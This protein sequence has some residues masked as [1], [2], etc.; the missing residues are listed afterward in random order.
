MSRLG[1]GPV[2]LGL[3]VLGLLVVAVATRP[4]VLA[5][6]GLGT[7]AGPVRTIGRQEVVA[8][9][10]QLGPASALGL[11]VMAA[12]GAMLLAR[13]LVAVVLGAV[14]LLAAGAAGWTALRVLLD[15][16]ASVLPVAAEG[17]A[18]TADSLDPAQVEASVTGWAVAGLA[19][20]VLAA[21]V[22]LVAVVTGRTWGASRRYEREAD[23]PAS[24]PDQAQTRDAV[25]D[26]WDALS[27]GEDPTERA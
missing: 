12:A 17:T 11:V 27:R 5:E 25:A 7:G 26:D 20:A 18:L 3:L 2:V 13:R 24:L 23:A 6:T 22:A 21:L 15:P 9:G 8:T 19:L 14:A 16:V 1:K 4:W 10:S